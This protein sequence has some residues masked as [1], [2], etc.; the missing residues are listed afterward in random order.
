MNKHL[1][2]VQSPRWETL[3]GRKKVSSVDYF[4]GATFSSG[5][6]WGGS[7]SLGHN[8]ALGD[9]TEANFGVFG[10]G[11]YTFMHEY[12]H[13]LQSQEY[14]LL[15]LPR[16]GGN[17]LSESGWTER[18]ANLRSANY[19]SN[20]KNGVNFTSWNPNYYR[21]ILNSP[22]QAK[23]SEFPANGKIIRALNFKRR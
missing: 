21:D 11:G 8:I 4:G 17:T 2:V 19:L 10:P 6:G 14:G 23:Y 1:R 16:I 7:V 9:D 13:Y 3:N 15:Y 5:A 18:D 12:G 22:G 20:P